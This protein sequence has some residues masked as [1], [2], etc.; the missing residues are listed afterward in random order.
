MKLDQIILIL[1]ALGALAYLGA[2]VFGML[3][4]MPYGLVGLGI[5]V[6]VLGI[7]GRIVYDRLQN[8][9]DDYYQKNVDK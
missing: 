4:I 7:F 6:S 5:I 2:M 1:L 8:K 3:Q 9:E